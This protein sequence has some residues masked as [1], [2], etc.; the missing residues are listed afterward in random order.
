[1]RAHNDVQHQLEGLLFSSLIFKIIRFWINV[2][3]LKE[4]F[5]SALVYNENKQHWIVLRV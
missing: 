2:C 1:M 5:T 3:A 4:G